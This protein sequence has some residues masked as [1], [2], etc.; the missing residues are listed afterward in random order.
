MHPHAH[1]GHP[2]AAAELLPGN[3]RVT[4]KAYGRCIE[5]LRCGECGLL[6]PAMPIDSSQIVALYRDMDDNTYL[7]GADMRGRSNARQ[8]LQILRQLRHP[9]RTALE[10]GAGSGFL[11]RE[12]RSSIDEVVGIEPSV[13]FC[14]W[15]RENLQLDL[16]QVGFEDYPVESRWD[17]VLALDVIEHVTDPDLFM[18]ALSRW[19][20]PGGV[21]LICTPDVGSLVAR[22]L[23]KK[24]WHIRPPHIFYFT[25]KAFGSLARRHGLDVVRTTGFSWTLGFGYLLESVLQL[26]FRRSPRWVTRLNFPVR[27]NTMDSALFVVRK[28]ATP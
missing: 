26:L 11:V 8:V 2:I 24:W 25:R 28:P 13:S 18:R 1:S 16:V 4:D 17:L 21:A 15:A 9:V 20:V 7:Q 19:L 12:L 22:T 23:G 3:M 27:V 14:T 5:V 6:Q 10:V